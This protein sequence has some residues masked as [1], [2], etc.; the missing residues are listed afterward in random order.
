MRSHGMAND[1]PMHALVD[2]IPEKAKTLRMAKNIQIAADTWSM[3]QHLK[4][5][6]K[7]CLVWTHQRNLNSV[8]VNQTSKLWWTV[9]SLIKKGGILILAPA[10]HFFRDD[11]VY[12]RSVCL[13]YGV[14]LETDFPLAPWT[15]R[16]S[17]GQ[18]VGVCVRAA[19]GL[20]NHDQPVAGW[21]HAR[22]GG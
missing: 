2:T 3:L 10:D 8:A 9:R 15:W 7:L 22:R 5:A 16:L 12:S 20:G 6:T 11:H 1:K 17:G 14:D 19:E 13:P 21:T 18:P 4:A